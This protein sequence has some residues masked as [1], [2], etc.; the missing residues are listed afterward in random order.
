MNSA[1][2]SESARFK[3][4]SEW[5]DSEGSDDAG[6][7]RG[8]SERFAEDCV[9]PSGSARGSNGSNGDDDFNDFN[10]FN[11]SIDDFNDSIDDLIQ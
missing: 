10:D 3:E 8:A 2:L 11:D 6:N 5:I 7:G 4:G 1:G 9:G